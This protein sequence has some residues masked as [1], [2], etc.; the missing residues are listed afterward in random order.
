M[1]KITDSQY[2]SL[3]G[4]IYS[5]IMG[6]DGMGMGEMGEAKDEAE[7]IVDDWMEENNIELI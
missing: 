6:M 7:R 2:K 1:T 4:F 5:S 3:I